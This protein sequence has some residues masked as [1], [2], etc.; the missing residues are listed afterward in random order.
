MAKKYLK[1]LIIL[2]SL[3]LVLLSACSPQVQSMS[4][5]TPTAKEDLAP[6][7][8]G[9]PSPTFQPG[10]KDPLP[11]P[12]V[13]VS[14]EQPFAKVPFQEGPFDFEFY[15]FQD[16]GFSQNPSM[17]WMYSDIP[18]V[19]THVSWVY[20]GPTLDKPVVESWGICPDI[21]PRDTFPGLKEGDSSI[22]EG[23]II[24]STG[25]HVRFRSAIR[26]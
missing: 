26:A 9:I 12:G 24:A 21:S 25:C 19:G 17:T 8:T 14:L 5:A 2:L 18:G 20:H 3:T 10:L 15:L 1:N 4:Q 11:T 23:G 13:S 22:R 7:S 6:V 16:P